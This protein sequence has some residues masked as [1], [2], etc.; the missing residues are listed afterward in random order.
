MNNFFDK[1]VGNGDKAKK[2]PDTSKQSIKNPFAQIGAALQGN[3]KKFEGR[4]E[5]LGGSKPGKVISVELK[6]PGPLGVKVSVLPLTVCI[7]FHG[8]GY[9]S[10]EIVFLVCI[11]C[12]I[13]CNCT[14][15]YL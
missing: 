6:H 8:F 12:F 13:C 10:L 9:Q 5:S 1:L 11:H 14:H 2:K 15:S 4:G 7:F 3:G